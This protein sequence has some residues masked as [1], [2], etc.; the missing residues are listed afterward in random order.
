MRLL[1][2]YWGRRG[3]GGQLT[4][5]LAEAL[6]RRPDAEDRRRNVLELTG[7]GRQALEQATRASDEAERRLL[8]ELDDEEAAQLRSLLRRV[9]RGGPRT[10]P[11]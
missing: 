3:A 6:A 2:W 1:F 7:A 5:A 10:T 4:L 11:S 8:A 9:G